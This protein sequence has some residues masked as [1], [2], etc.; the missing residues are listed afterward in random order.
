MNANDLERGRLRREWRT[1]A[2]MI[3][4]SCTQRHGGRRGALCADCR[5]LHDYAQL[6]LTRCPFGPDKPTCAHCRV[7]CYRPEMRERV[8]DVMRF[9]GPRMLSRHPWLAVM[10]L[11][12]DDRRPAPERPARSS[13]A[14]AD[15]GIR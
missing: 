2:A 4:I 8:R 13:A 14:A 9:A 12:V 11:L 6:R 3:A 15:T 7:H 1:L 5:E 10:H